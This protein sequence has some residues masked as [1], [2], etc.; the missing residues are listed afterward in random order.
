MGKAV[1]FVRVSTLK[2][3]LESQEADLR[4]CAIFDGFNESDIIY[5]GKKESGYKLEEDEREGLEEL[6]NL[7]EQEDI[8][9]VYIWEISRLSRKP[10][11]LY[12]I[13]DKL[14]EN[15]I[16][17]KCLN[18]QF[19]LLDSERS[20]YDNTANIIFS[21]FG[22]MAYQE[23]VE[24]KERFARGKKRLAEEGRYNGGAI[25]FGYKIDKERGNLIVIN[26]EEAEVVREIYTMYENGFSQANIAKEFYARNQKRYTISF[27]H[28]ILTN[29]LLT[30]VKQ[31]G[32]SASY[33]RAYPAII[34]IEQFE[35][36]RKIALN[37]NTTASKAKNIYFAD[38]IIKCP[39]CGGKFSASGSKTLYRCYK[40]NYTNKDINGYDGI[41]LCTNKTNISIN[42]VDSILWHL[43]QFLESDYILNS[44]QDDIDNLNKRKND[45][46]V[47]VS[48][49]EPLLNEINIK[50]EK[51]REMYI[52]GLSK[53]T[54]N[55]RKSLLDSEEKEIKSKEIEYNNEIKHIEEIIERILSTY[56]ITDTIKEADIITNNICSIL[57]EI[58]SIDDDKIRYDIIHRHIKQVTIEDCTTKHKFD[59]HDEE[60]ETKARNIIVETYIGGTFNYKF[61][62]FDGKGGTIYVCN[63]DF[64]IISK[65]NIQY[66]KRFIDRKKIEKRE[67]QKIERKLLKEKAYKE[68]KIKG[69]L[70]LREAEKYSKIN[71]TTLWYAS[72]DGR[73]K[74]QIIDKV[75]YVTIDDLNR[76]AEIKRKSPQT[77]RR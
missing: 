24:K 57:N 28:Q 30:G 70:T 59:C 62:P 19:T 14:L 25:P 60:T 52:D 61:I 74:S 13:S 31:K 64:E 16:Q 49:I 42:V 53:E 9:T 71:Y 8:D 1:I 75:K 6:H 3:N 72:K 33:E 10:K 7:I 2:Q 73:L 54:F 63:S 51:L 40:A 44:A 29:R 21:L 15:K 76:F 34:T 36:C 47:K 35:N 50:R 41:T 77:N 58:E 20:K 48:N 11:I 37:N 65:A 68:R 17:L 27:V 69:L 45:L 26:E 46:L 22:A 4:K 23:V 5:I 38:K 56:N 43:A 67:I 55:K 66:L 12:S 32:K 39:I 18:P